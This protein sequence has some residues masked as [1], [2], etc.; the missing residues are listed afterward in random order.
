MDD[1]YNSSTHGMGSILTYANLI[2]STGDSLV[3]LK[4]L[5]DLNCYFLPN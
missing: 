5:T 1:G 2:N 3:T 4:A